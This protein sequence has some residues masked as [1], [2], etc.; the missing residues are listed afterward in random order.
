[1]SYRYVLSGIGTLLLNG[2]SVYVPMQGAAPD[3]RGKGELEVAGSWSLTNRLEAGATYS[4]ARHVLV[5]AATS[6]KPALRATDGTGKYAQVNQYQLAAGTYWPLGRRGLV[7][8]L[9]AFGQTHAKARYVND[10]EDG[11]T[12]YPQAPTNFVQ[13]QF[14]AIYSKYSG[15]A[16]GSWQ[17][18]PRLSLGLSYRVVQV[19]LTDV[20]DA[21]V[22]VRASPILRYES[23]L[24][25]RLRPLGQAGAVQVQAA[26]G[27]S[28]VFGSITG[29]G[30]DPA[31]Q[32]RLNRSYLSL[33]LAFYPH[34]LWQKKPAAKVP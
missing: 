20:T 14:D 5:R 31:R 6:L 32:F 16:Y 26:S 19:R 11:Y 22:P 27:W 15:E 28:S 10:D 12:I 21:G 29:D 13:H 4:P 2:C 25:C 18:S 17:L 30:F 34:V 9:V 24:F 23:M 1:M 33:G 8:G 7:G 3:I